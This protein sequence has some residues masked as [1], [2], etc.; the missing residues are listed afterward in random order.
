M[1]LSRRSF[2]VG[3]AAALLA[4]PP[5]ARAAIL[6][7]EDDGAAGRVEPTPDRPTPPP[8]PPL[9]P[10]SRPFAAGETLSY[11]VEYQGIRAGD[12]T[13]AVVGPS[14]VEDLSGLLVR[15]TGETRG[16][17]AKFY[18][19]EDRVETLLDPLFLFA[20][21]TETWSQQRDRFRHRIVRF[22]PK[23][24][25]Y[26]RREIPGDTITGPLETPVVEG[27]GLIYH[28]R[29][30]PLVPG[31]RLTVPVFRKQNVTSITFAARGPVLVSTPA[32]RFETVE[33]RPVEADGRD[34]DEAGLFGGHATIWLTNDARRIPVRLA[35]SARVGSLEAR[36]QEVLVPGPVSAR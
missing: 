4:C 3:G 5:G 21:R 22:E 34:T 11:S 9:T 32:G 6:A 36:L 1:P 35:G 18:R 23:A 13:L 17:V 25:R 26:V 10:G 2:L 8:Y 16:L 30:K 33:I 19:M 28:L 12:A 14:E 15:Y 20:R 29:V 27:L 24:G 31:G 7:R